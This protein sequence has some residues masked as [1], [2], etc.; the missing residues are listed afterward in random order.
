MFNYYNF[1]LIIK[2]YNFLL[3]TIKNNDYNKIEVLIR[4][5]K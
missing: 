2:Q 5:K 4:L 3:I 1:L